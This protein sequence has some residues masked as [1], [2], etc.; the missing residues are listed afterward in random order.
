MHLTDGVL[1]TP[2]MIATNV[3]ALGGVGFGLHRLDFERVPRVGLLAS[4]FF[5]ASFVHVNIGPVSAHLLLNGL[6]G[7]LLGWA[8]FPALGAA[9]LLQAV[10]LAYGGLTAWGANLLT[11]AVPAVL[12]HLLCSRACR[13]GTSSRHAFGWGAL[14]GG[15][16]V[17]LSCLLMAAALHLSDPRGYS[18]VV[19]GV[20]IVHIPVV[21]IEAVAVGA[22][23]AFLRQVR[24]ELLEPPLSSATEPVG[25]VSSQ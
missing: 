15:L 10:L 8:A 13:S 18:A 3:A 5:V 12:C 20:L 9:L 4:A 19:K 21:A 22:A 16:S 6:V 14:G 2:V 7:L 25:A 1:S 24:P 17:V 11:M 23:A